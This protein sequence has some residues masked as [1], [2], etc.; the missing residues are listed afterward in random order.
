LKD[1][2]NNNK[3]YAWLS[4]AKKPVVCEGLDKEFLSLSKNFYSS[5]EEGVG[6]RNGFLWNDFTDSEADFSNKMRGCV[7]ALLQP[8]SFYVPTQ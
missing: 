2:L 5:T 3:E 6:F 8:T 7:F 1:F 4:L